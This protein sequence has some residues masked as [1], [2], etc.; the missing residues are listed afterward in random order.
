MFGI[1]FAII[2][3][4]VLPV[5]IFLYAFYT[6]HSVPFLLGVFTFVLS[7]MILRIPIMNYLS[8][9]S[10]SYTMFSITHPILYVVIIGF[11]AGVF[12]EVARHMVMRYVM[13]QQNWSAGFFFGTGH[14]G[15][16]AIIFLGISAVTLIFTSTVTISSDAYI[17]GGMERFFAILLHIGLSMIVLLGVTKKKLRYLFIAIVIHGVVDSFV[18]L[19]PMLFSTELSLWIIEGL[20]IIVSVTLMTYSIQLKRRGVL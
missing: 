2:I 3:S 14:G 1:V 7:Q 4:F 17:I 11:S 20:L 9:H 12:E 8:T 13:K 6:K 5:G 10:T 19:V 15:I 18:G 16:E